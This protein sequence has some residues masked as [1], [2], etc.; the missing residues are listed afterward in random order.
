[1]IWSQ[2]DHGAIAITAP[3]QETLLSDIKER[4]QSRQG[5]SVAT[6]N[7]DHIVKLGRNEAFRAAYREQTHVTADGNPIVWLSRLSGQ[8]DVRLVPGSELVEPVAALAAEENVPVAL[9]GASETALQTA[10]DALRKR[11]G[12]LDITLTKAPSMGFDPQGSEADEAIDII[13]KSGARLV[14]V[15]LGAPKQEIFAAHA[16]ARLP[17]VGFL[18]VG[19]GLDFVAET[20]TRA[21]AWVRRMAAEWLWRLIGNPRRMAGRYAACI[22]VLPGLFGR[23]LATRLSGRQKLVS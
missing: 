8:S 4:F 2:K 12:T 11:H 3:D 23:A 13:E 5:F 22:L 21:P 9:F 18:S 16:Q 7:L 15:A 17:E 1:M 19:A 14:F 6:L 20:Q 10:A